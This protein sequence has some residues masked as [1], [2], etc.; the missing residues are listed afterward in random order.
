MS[1][2]L[3]L[4]L[5]GGESWTVCLKA[6]V[7]RANEN[8]GAESQNYRILLMHVGYLLEDKVMDNLST[9]LMY[10]CNNNNHNNNTNNNNSTSA[11]GYVAGCMCLYVAETLLEKCFTERNLITKL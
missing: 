9:W 4:C 2:D 6:I 3:T 10:S 8:R 1:A 11:H 5:A 7:H